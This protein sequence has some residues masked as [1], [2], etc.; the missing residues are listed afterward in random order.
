MDDQVFRRLFY[1]VLL[2]YGIQF[3]FMGLNSAGSHLRPGKRITETR[4]DWELF[5]DYSAWIPGA[6]LALAGF[7]MCVHAIFMALRVSRSRFPQ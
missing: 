4:S 1:V 5:L 3:F 2:I 6:V 7:L